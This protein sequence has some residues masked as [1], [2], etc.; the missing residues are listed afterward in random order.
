MMSERDDL[1]ESVPTNQGDSE[2][3]TVKESSVVLL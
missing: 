1:P 2:C 3:E